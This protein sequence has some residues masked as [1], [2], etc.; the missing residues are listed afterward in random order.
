MGSS[1]QDLDTARAA[2]S[3]LRGSVGARV[4]SSTWRRRAQPVSAGPGG[5]LRG[6][7]GGAPAVRRAPIAPYLPF[8][9]RTG[10]Q[11]IAASAPTST[12]TPPPRPAR[13]ARDG[14]RQELRGYTRPPLGRLNRQR[15]LMPQAEIADGLV[16]WWPR[17][18]PWRRWRRCV[19]GVGHELHGLVAKGRRPALAAW[20]AFPWEAYHPRGNPLRLPGCY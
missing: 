5:P 8:A 11:A 2:R 7:R 4:G 6:G 14:G 13:Q 10:P 9:S 18:D 15:P 16:L 12:T 17:P 3:V 19:V 1:A 20:T